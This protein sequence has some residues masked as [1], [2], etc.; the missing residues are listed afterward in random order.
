MDSEFKQFERLVGVL[1]DM[2]R[3]PKLPFIV[4]ARYVSAKAELVYPLLLVT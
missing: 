1:M 2:L 3:L 4:K